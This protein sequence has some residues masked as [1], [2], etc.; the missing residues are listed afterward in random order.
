MHH[1]IRN[2]DYV[3]DPVSFNIHFNNDLSLHADFICLASGGYPKTSMFDW[4]IQTGH[5]I[6]EPVP[7]LFTFNMP[8][9]LSPH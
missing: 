7:S 3:K 4:I 1:G 2:I 6:E 8:G 5:S 9:N